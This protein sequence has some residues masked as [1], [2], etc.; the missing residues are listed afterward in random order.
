M[1]NV[2]LPIET[3]KALD[4]ASRE[5]AA[6]LKILMEG[7]ETVVTDFL[8]KYSG[9]IMLRDRLKSDLLALQ[10]YI[11]RENKR[12]KQVFSDLIGTLESFAGK[13]GAGN[14]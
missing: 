1:D 4:I 14:D 11:P 3:K 9:L 2:I 12:A 5:V 6:D 10:Y 8:A 7:S 13:C